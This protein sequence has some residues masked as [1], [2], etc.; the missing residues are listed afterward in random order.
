[1]SHLVEKLKKAFLSDIKQRVDHLFEEADNW[2][3]DR[4][5]ASGDPRLQQQYTE[6]LRFIKLHR[7]HFERNFFQSLQANFD[8]LQAPTQNGT[9]DSRVQLRDVSLDALSLVG[10][11]EMEQNV[12]LDSMVVRCRGELGS[13]LARVQ[14]RLQSLLPGKRLSS[15]NNPF[16]PKAIC[17]ALGR[18]VTDIPWDVKHDLIFFKLF[19][20]YV[21][22]SFPQVVAAMDAMLVQSGVLKDFSERELLQYQLHKRYSKPP[23]TQ[24]TRSPSNRG[25]AAPSSGDQGSSL[26]ANRDWSQILQ[27]ALAGL[28][29][30][31]A[32]SGPAE[33][34]SQSA[35]AVALPLADLVSVLAQIPVSAPSDAG[36]G[37]WRA[38]QLCQQINGRVQ[39]K[40]RNGQEFKVDSVDTNIIN[41]VSR[42]FEQV[43]ERGALPGR[44]KV[45]LARLQI[46]FIRIALVDP[47]F[48]ASSKHPA[49]QLINEMADAGLEVGDS[50]EGQSDAVFSR[51][52]AVIDTILSDYDDDIS[53]LEGLCKDFVGF[54]QREARRASLVAQ[55]MAALEEGKA[56]S[57][58]VNQD[59]A[60]ALQKLVGDQDI[61]SSFA[62]VLDKIWYSYLCWIHHREGKD[63]FAWNKALFQAEQMQ[64]CLLPVESEQEAEDRLVAI[65]ELEQ[66]IRESAKRISYRGAGLDSQ[67]DELIGLMQEKA[68]Y[69]P[70]PAA[71]AQAGGS[72]TENATENAEPDA[73]PEA[74]PGSGNLADRLRAPRIPIQKASNTSVDSGKVTRLDLARK[75]H[76]GSEPE[77]V[78]QPL[79]D[80]DPGLLKAQQLAVG[81]LMDYQSAESAVRCKLA[82]YIKS[83]D[84]LIFVDRSGVKLFEKS[85]LELAHDINQG[86][87]DLLEDAMLFDRALESVISSLRDV[88]QRAV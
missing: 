60:E 50:P 31:A 55:R 5:D 1:M 68:R 17:E 34:G 85:T 39:E 59:V 48:L 45:L 24:P 6:M 78:L 76:T 70:A 36:Q 71:D 38:D 73:I 77:K 84:K 75:A 81:T 26:P 46:P 80:N 16:D 11:D 47:D 27:G 12:A 65:D 23:E 21:L 61:P 4:V 44:V 7:H 51:I 58:Q 20:Q 10:H 35:Q 57:A 14:A 22:G 40:N 41:L 8:Q 9:D 74:S 32:F 72:A 30:P 52:Q 33:L 79:P 49:R 64:V 63:S 3:M 53:L 86:K 25:E 88:R 19:Q 66:A 54:R 43:L 67:L 42:L 87:V 62:W 13:E 37:H 28:Q 18:A 2:L 15:D 69:V 56:K 82:A 29:H 83:I